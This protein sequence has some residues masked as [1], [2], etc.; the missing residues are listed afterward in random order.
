MLFLNS[1]SSVSSVKLA[2]SI[3]FSGNSR[4]L[5]RLYRGWCSPSD[6]RG[7]R[8]LAGG[9]PQRRLRKP[10]LIAA[11]VACLLSIL[12]LQLWLSIRQESQT[13]DEANHIYAGLQI[14]D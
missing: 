10:V 5:T 8:C 11:G 12:S 6:C 13:W 7:T 9:R 14:L 2:S 3:W 4:V 1:L